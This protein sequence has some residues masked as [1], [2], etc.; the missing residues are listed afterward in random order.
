MDQNFIN[1]IMSGF[2]ILFII[3]LAAF[4]SVI[5]YGIKKYKKEKRTGSIFV[6]FL[7]ASFLFCVINQLSIVLFSSIAL[8]CFLAK[9]YI[10]SV[11]YTKI[12][13]EIAIFP[14][15]KGNLYGELG[16]RQS[17]G[18][19]NGAKAI[20]SFDKAYKLTK[21]YNPEFTL[22]VIEPTWPIFA[23]LIY[24]VKGDYDKSAEIAKERKMYNRL[25]DC[26]YEQK[27]YN[28]A[29]FYINK[30]IKQHQGTKY[31]DFA[32]RSRIHKK[33]GNFD[34]AQKD[35]EIALKLCNKKNS[36]INSVKKDSDL[37]NYNTLYLEQRKKLGF[38]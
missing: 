3:V 17:S 15:Q 7:V 34:L 24:F 6:T 20:E 31:L 26:Y 33:M 37:E 5:I 29:L 38:E 9:D 16:I 21:T 32:T 25:A 19:N 35:Y 12:A 1:F 28:S 8:D 30:S 2:I 23:S 27:D 14:M 36:C 11:K 22:G 18:L 13:A 10:N 4:I